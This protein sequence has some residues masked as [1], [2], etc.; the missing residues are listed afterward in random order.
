MGYWSIFLKFKT[1]FAYVTRSKTCFFMNGKLEMINI[2]ADF[3]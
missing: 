2:F 3:N 1:G